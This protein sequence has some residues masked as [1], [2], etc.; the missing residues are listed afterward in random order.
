MADFSRTTTL[1]PV[2]LVGLS[3]DHH[4]MQ[5][6]PAGMM[7][8]IEGHVKERLRHTDAVL[9]LLD[10]STSASAEELDDPLVHVTQ[11]HSLPTSVFFPHALEGAA[12]DCS[13]QDLRSWAQVC[14][15]WSGWT[16]RLLR[17]PSALR[18]LWCRLVL[19]YIEDL[20]LAR[21]LHPQLAGRASL[22]AILQEQQLR[23]RSVLL[24]D[25]EVD[26]PPP[27]LAVDFIGGL[28]DMWAYFANFCDEGICR[29]HGWTTYL[30]Y[31]P[32]LWPNGE[33]AAVGDDEL[34][35]MQDLTVS[36][37]EACLD[38]L[39][40]VKEFNAPANNLNLSALLI[41]A[42]ENTLSQ[43]DPLWPPNPTT[44]PPLLS[45]PF[46]P[47]HPNS[48]RCFSFCRSRSEKRRIRA[49]RR[50]SA[51]SSRRPRPACL[52]RRCASGPASSPSGRTSTVRRGLPRIVTVMLWCRHQFT[53]V[54]WRASS[55]PTQRTK[56]TLGFGCSRVGGGTPAR[57]RRRL[58]R[59]Q[60]INN[61]RA[62]ESAAIRAPTL[63]FTHAQTWPRRADE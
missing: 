52:P 46:H 39:E 5:S 33:Y 60:C 6:N 56:G 18:W 19:A 30:G 27:V 47:P 9:K 35:A 43:A 53:P 11:D 15:A 10:V 38:Y 36:M 8:D 63:F 44:P 3:S 59:W 13:A 2:H 7:S 34:V 4:N 61:C 40:W 37:F 31:R 1:R 57:S 16:H 25:A 49:S 45:H 42:L 51:S 23:D 21:V 26:T 50:R 29:W 41:P 24:D 32:H 14:K 12:K 62:R 17:D 22:R 20:D 48:S 54:G 28:A 58:C 55:N